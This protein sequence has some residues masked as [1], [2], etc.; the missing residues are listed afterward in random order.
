[1]YEMANIERCLKL[2]HRFKVFGSD[3]TPMKRNL[4]CRDCSRGEVTVIVASG[5]DVGSFGT[6][7]KPRKE[8]HENRPTEQH[9]DQ[10]GDV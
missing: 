10:S 9:D 4:M 1:M 7:I 5:T 8:K 2:K 6:C 3:K